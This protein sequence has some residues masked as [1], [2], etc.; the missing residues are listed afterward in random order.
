MFGDA[1]VVSVETGDGQASAFSEEGRL[2]FKGSVPN[3]RRTKEQKLMFHQQAQY[4]A[5]QHQRGKHVKVTTSFCRKQMLKL[6]RIAIT[7]T[8]M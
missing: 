4:T 6:S 1:K 2:S 8:S 3:I 5:K 7:I